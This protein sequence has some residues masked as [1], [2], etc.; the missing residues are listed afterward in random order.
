MCVKT[1]WQL[2]WHHLTN[3]TSTP[4]SLNR[5]RRR[6]LSLTETTRQHSSP[7]SRYCSLMKTQ[8]R[9]SSLRRSSQP[10][11]DG[12]AAAAG[13]TQS[14]LSPSLTHFEGTRIRMNQHLVCSVIFLCCG[15]THAQTHDVFIFARC[16]YLSI[17]RFLARDSMPS[18]LYA[19]ANLSVRLSVCLS[20]GWI[21]RK[22]LKLG[23]CNF[24]RTAAPP[25]FC[26]WYKFHPENPTGS[27]QAGASNKGETS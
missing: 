25:L 16:R 8:M 23:S 5:T 7:S 20:N 3:L 26:L 21:S 13:L 17:L 1:W 18:A 19:I 15:V 22:W 11:R 6:T 27:P 14:T 9:D 12:S 4:P 2:E 10:L 24:H